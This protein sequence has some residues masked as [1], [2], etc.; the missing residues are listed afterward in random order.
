MKLVL[1]KIVNKDG[2]PCIEVK[3]KDAKPKVFSPEKVSA[4]IL[5]KIK[6]TVRHSL[7]RKSIKDVVVI[8]VAIAYGFDSKGGEKNI[9]VFDLGGG[10]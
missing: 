8:V 9:L 2:K 3:I 7:G 4:M 5:I 10:T 1:H 6:E